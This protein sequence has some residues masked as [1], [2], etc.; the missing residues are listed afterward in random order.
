MKTLLL[1]I[2]PLVLA[3]QTAFADEPAY[4]NP[5]NFFKN[6]ISVQNGIWREHTFRMG[7]V[8]LLGGAIGMSLPNKV[9]GYAEENSTASIGEKFCTWYYNDGNDIASTLFNHFYVTNP[10]EV[11]VVTGPQEYRETLKDQFAKSNI[12]FLSCIEQHKYLAMGC[13]GQMHRGPTVFGMLLSFSGCSSKNSLAI[14]NKLWGQNGVKPEVRQAI[15]EEGYKLGNEDAE[16]R[17][18]MQKALGY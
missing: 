4:C 11:T 17:L 12:S 10:K 3:V 7:D 6:E 15:I 16:A 14:V 8:I 13:N 1:L 2:L 18:R 9:T 5:E